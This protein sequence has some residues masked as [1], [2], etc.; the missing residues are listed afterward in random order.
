MKNVLRWAVAAALMVLMIPRVY[1][2]GVQG[3]DILGASSNPI[4]MLV[5]TSHTSSAGDFGVGSLILGFKLYANDA[6]DGCGLYDV[7]TAPAATTS[8]LIDEWIEATDE[9]TNVHLWPRPYKLA[10]DLSV[11]TNG[12]CIIYYQ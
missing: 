10:T 4:K 11:L 7:A 3:G 9:E 2:D 6:G 12:V 8:N 5:V 1:A